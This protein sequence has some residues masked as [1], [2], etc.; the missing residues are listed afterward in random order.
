[1]S[2]AEQK[3]KQQEDIARNVA[4]IYGR[5]KEDAKHDPDKRG[6]LPTRKFID[7]D[8]IKSF[9]GEHA[10]LDPSYACPV[11]LPDELFVTNPGPTR[12]PSY[13]HAL[14]ATRTPDI[15]KRHEVR[16]AATVREAKKIASKASTSD[17]KERCLVYAKT[18]LRDK[19]MRNKGLKALLMKTEKR[20]LA[21]MPEFGDLYWGLDASGKGQNQYGKLL[22]AI[23]NE[24]SKGDDLDM[25]IKDYAK[26]IDPENVCMHIIVEK[27]NISVTEDCK[28]FLSKS[29][30]FIGKEDDNDVVAAHGNQFSPLPSFF[31]RCSLFYTITNRQC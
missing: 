19:F 25:W 10:F 14:Q 2:S 5:N 20:T 6:F 17:W 9:S 23:R 7:V 12:Y 18:L 16:D 8:A 24:I 22:E 13:E 28:S 31:F 29:C 26:L 1:M 11:Y 21:Y 3:R 15:H 30:I 4:F 27:D